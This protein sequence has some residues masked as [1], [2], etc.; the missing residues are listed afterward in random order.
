VSDWFVGVAASVGVGLVAG[1]DARMFGH[2]RTFR[3]SNIKMSLVHGVYL[4]SR[5]SLHTLNRCQ[6]SL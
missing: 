4:I 6:P 1:P 5:I 3:I 2:L